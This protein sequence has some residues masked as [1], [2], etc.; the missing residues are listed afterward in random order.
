VVLEGA[1]GP[2]RYVFAD[3]ELRTMDS[4]MSRIGR[5]LHEGTWAGR[6]SGI[7]NL[8]AAI[9][10]LWMLGS[11]ALSFVRRRARRGALAPATS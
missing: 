11:G 1:S 9:A 7:L 5:E 4:R 2:V 10:M 6:W 3:G 8:A